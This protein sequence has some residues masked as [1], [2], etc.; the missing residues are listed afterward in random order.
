MMLWIWTGMLGSLALAQPLIGEVGEDGIPEALRAGPDLPE[1]TEASDFDPYAPLQVVGGVV[2]EV[3]FEGQ[4]TLMSL[5]CD[6][7]CGW[8]L[9][10]RR[11]H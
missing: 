1:I 8:K 7:R 10:M 2:T 3:Q 9:V 4:D 6:L 11:I 5:Y